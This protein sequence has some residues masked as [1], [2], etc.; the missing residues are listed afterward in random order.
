M[1]IRL[2]AAPA[3]GFD[4]PLELLSECHRR[5]EHFL[6]I[7][8][9]VAHTAGPALDAAQ[10]K[11]VEAAL[12]YFRTAAPRHNEDEERSL[13][14]LLRAC[15]GSEVAAAFEAIGTLEHDHQDAEPAHQEVDRLYRQWIEAGAL[16][17]RDRQELIR[18]LD[19]LTQMYRRHIEVEDRRIFPLAAGALNREQL[20]RL[21]G[22]MARRR[23]L[24]FIAPQPTPTGASA[25]TPQ[26]T[27][28]VRTIPGPQRHPMIFKTFESLQPG[29]ALEIVNNHDPM[30][31]HNQFTF[32]KKGQFTWDYLE[33]GPEVWRVRIARVAA[34][35][36]RG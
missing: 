4:E 8:H 34:E 17:D 14:P 3:H 16:G 21:G 31:L 5:I 27:I 24:T 13:F 1:P 11:A 15:P 12:T 33:Q 10:Q 36:P 20:G 23:G 25:M 22:E 7:L 19:N 30:P 26:H 9:K 6:G 35:Y 2:G 28:D 32:M 18:L 29:E